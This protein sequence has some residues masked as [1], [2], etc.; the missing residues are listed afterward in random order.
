MSKIKL[1][2]VRT[3]KDIIFDSVFLI[4]TVAVWCIIVWLIHRAPNV[5]PTHW[6]PSGTPDAYGPPTFFITPGIIMTVV[7][8]ICAFS[9][10]LPNGSINLPGIEGPG[11]ARQRRL[12]ILLSRIIAL[13]ILAAMLFTAVYMLAMKKHDSALPWVII[14][15]SMIGVSLVFTVLIYKAK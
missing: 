10:Y 14:V 1:N 7:A 5:V 4:L 2:V 15:G 9:I 8:L 11:N 3:S 13:I 6:G 12:G